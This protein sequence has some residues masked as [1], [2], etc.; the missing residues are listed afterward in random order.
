MSRRW[1]WC[2][3]SS[4]LIWTMIII[5]NNKLS[6]CWHVSRKNKYYMWRQCS[7]GLFT[8]LI[9]E[10]YRERRSLY[11]VPFEMSEW[12]CE[13]VSEWVGDLYSHW[14]GYIRDIWPNDD[15]DNWHGLRYLYLSNL[16]IP[17]SK[18]LLK[19]FSE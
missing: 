11:S 15:T 13:W 19:D 18:A 14:T 10:R 1:C 16:T 2:Q 17:Y 4:F 12:V 7:F 6:D 9:P 5:F 8:L 3:P